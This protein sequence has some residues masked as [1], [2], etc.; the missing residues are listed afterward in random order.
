MND[1]KEVFMNTQGNKMSTKTLVLGAVLTAL[2]VILQMMGASI[3]IGMFSI[4]LVLIPIVIGAATCGSLIGAWLGF[5]FGI[6]V[7]LSGDAAPFMAI[8]VPGTV[9]IVLLKGTACGYLAGLVY[10]LLEKKNRYLAVIA[11]AIVCPIVNTGIFLIGCFLFFTEFL[12]ET[13]QAMGF[14]DNVAKFI[15][16]GLVG[17]NFLI[18]L[19]INVVLS[20]IVVRILNI[21]IRN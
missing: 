18:E 2:V 10:K 5:V 4:S 3:K 9:L 11:A 7:L 1:S 13:A 15:L 8:T 14:G 12:T 6:V 16:F 21:K 17:F 20:P 19:G